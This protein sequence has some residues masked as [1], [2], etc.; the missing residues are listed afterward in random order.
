[1]IRLL[2]PLGSKSSKANEDQGLVKSFGPGPLVKQIAK[3]YL[4]PANSTAI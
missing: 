1:M 4:W 3:K 2:I